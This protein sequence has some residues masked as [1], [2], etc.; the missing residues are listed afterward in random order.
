MVLNRIVGGADSNRGEWPWQV[1]LKFKSDF[2][3]GGSLITDTWVLTAAHCFNSVEV[4]DYTVYIGAYQ[5]TDLQN[6]YTVSRD[7]KRIIVHPDF[8]YEGS[9]GDIALIELVE[10]VNSTSNIL[11]VCL[12]SQDVQFEEGTKCWVTGW[13]H[14]REG[15]PLGDPKTMQEA[16]VGLI[17]GAIC[18][19]MYHKSLGYF[20]NG[21]I[22]QEDMV[23]AGYKEGQIDSCQGDSGGPLVCNVNNVWLQYGIVSWGLGCARANMPGVYTKVQYYAAWIEQYADTVI[24]SQGGPR[25][26]LSIGTTANQ[27]G[28][29]NSTETIQNFSTNFTTNATEPRVEFVKSVENGGKTQR[30]SLIIIAII[31]LCVLCS[32]SW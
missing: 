32:F 9:S 2:I 7:L 23:C 19:V 20:G 11:P 28:V 5:L 8:M 18:E 13:G 1:S 29:G 4:S 16:S 25:K 31:I 21:Q 10:G 26:E 30:L 6:P 24:F 15:T 14:I 3:C 22:I 17:D 27:V 12:P